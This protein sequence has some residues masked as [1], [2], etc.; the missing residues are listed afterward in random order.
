MDVLT[1]EF[2]VI[3][4]CAAFPASLMSGSPWGSKK[5]RNHAGLVFPMHRHGADSRA[6]LGRTFRVRWLSKLVPDL[7][8]VQDEVQS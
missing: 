5:S 2:T 7:S 8:G 4:E 1:R 6:D 3:V